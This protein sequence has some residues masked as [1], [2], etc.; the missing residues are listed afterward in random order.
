M[1]LPETTHRLFEGAHNVVLT[2]VNPDGSPQTSLL[3]GAR[4]GDQIVMG[5]GKHMPKVRNIR[6]NPRV[7]VLVED[8]QKDERGL[9]QYL[10]V[11]GTATIVG[12]DIADDYAELMDAEARR[13]LGVEEFLL[14]PRRPDP[15][16]VIVRVTPHRITGN[17]PWAQKN[18]RTASTTR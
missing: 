10:L 6:L 11:Y 16:A 18:V 1:R 12:P 8:D 2:T 15:D 14:G 5:M 13:Y 4:D 9:N 17:G 3:W 7:S